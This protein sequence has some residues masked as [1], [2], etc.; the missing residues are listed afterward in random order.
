V[1]AVWLFW[2]NVQLAKNSP[3]GFWQ[4][5]RRAAAA[6]FWLFLAENA[7]LRKTHHRGFAQ[8]EGSGFRGIFR[9]PGVDLGSCQKFPTWFSDSYVGPRKFLLGAHK[10]RAT[11]VVVH[12]GLHGFW[13]FPRKV[14]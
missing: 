5:G 14:P 11:L 7:V 13:W 6:A 9:V 2:G 4:V 8:H 12:E 3:L 10:E 1:R